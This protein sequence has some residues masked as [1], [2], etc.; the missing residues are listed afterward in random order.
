MIKARITEIIGEYAI[1]DFGGI[2]RIVPKSDLPQRA[3]KGDVVK[4]RSGK[5]VLITNQLH[6]C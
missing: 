2:A 4:Y 5:L 6:T 3:L 1:I